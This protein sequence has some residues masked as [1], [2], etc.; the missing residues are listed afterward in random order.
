MTGAAKTPITPEQAATIRSAH[1]ALEAC[2]RGKSGIR[3]T[4]DACNVI[5]SLL[6]ILAGLTGIDSAGETLL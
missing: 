5:R 4:T 6:D 3:T 2:Y 1:A